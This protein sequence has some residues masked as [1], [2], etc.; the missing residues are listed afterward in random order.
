MGWRGSESRFTA[1]EQQSQRIQQVSPGR[2]TI[3]LVREVN[4]LTKNSPS[5]R[6]CG[7]I[8]H[9]AKPGTIR[10]GGGSLRLEGPEKEWT[11]AT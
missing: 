4:F 10:L 9:P 7:E 11:D 1:N 2:P 6:R 8:Q 3:R 5:A